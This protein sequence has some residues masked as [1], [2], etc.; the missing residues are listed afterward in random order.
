MIGFD[1]FN[2]GGLNL[3]AIHCYWTYQCTRSRTCAWFWS[4]WSLVPARWSLPLSGLEL[5]I[6]TTVLTFVM[7][8]LNV[9]WLVPAYFGINA[10]LIW[11]NI[12]L[13]AMLSNQGPGSSFPYIS[14]AR[15]MLLAS[16]LWCGTAIFINTLIWN[17]RRRTPTSSS[18]WT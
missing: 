1:E 12:E 16:V 5:P 9:G 11:I 18:Q 10:L 13:P 14:F 6:K 17:Q 7:P 4:G 2:C 8:I 15:E 3:F